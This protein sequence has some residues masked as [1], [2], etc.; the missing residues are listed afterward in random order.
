MKNNP[1]V[2]NIIVGFASK[3]FF[4]ALHGLKPEK[5]LIYH[6]GNI[7]DIIVATPVYRSICNAFLDA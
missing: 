4:G 5:V 7:G 1:M 2:S 3:V 6:V